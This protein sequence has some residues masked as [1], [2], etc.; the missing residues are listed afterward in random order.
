MFLV[1]VTR[2]ACACNYMHIYVLYVVPLRVLSSEERVQR[3][4]RALCMAVASLKLVF[5][6]LSQDQ[7]SSS[8]KSWEEFLSEKKLWALSRHSNASVSHQSGF[9]GFKGFCTK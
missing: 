1:N 6:N 8:Q 7:L 3:Y 9:G 4:E 5:Q 2:H